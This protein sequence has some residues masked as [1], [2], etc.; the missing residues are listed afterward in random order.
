MPPA[1][2]TSHNV[3][4]PGECPVVTRSGG[5]TATTSHCA[6]PVVERWT[7][8]P[9]TIRHRSA[10]FG[11]TI[12]TG[13]ADRCNVRLS[14]SFFGAAVVPLTTAGGASA[15]A[16]VAGGGAGGGAAGFDNRLSRNVI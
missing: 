8:R 7:C 3:D 15:A 13:A 11:D 12:S 5:C 16:A 10:G 1:R 9:S 4:G 14:T 6:P 2:P